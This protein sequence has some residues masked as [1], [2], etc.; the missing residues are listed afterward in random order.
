MKNFPCLIRLLFQKTLI[1]K[2]QHCVRSCNVLFSSFLL[3][4]CIFTL[5]STASIAQISIPENAQL[6]VYGNGWVC[7]RGFRQAGDKCVRVTMPENAQLNVYGNGW[8]CQMGF[9][10]VS[11]SCIEMSPEEAE[12]QRIQM[13]MLAARAKAMNKEFYVDGEK[14][15]LAEISRK[16]DVYRYSDNYG[17]IECSG[18][19]LRAVERKCE[20]YFSGRYEKTGELECRGSDLNPIE[21]NC[22]ATMYSD[23]YADI[24]C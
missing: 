3:S 8:V 9:K 11:Q 15:T 18:S 1:K 14:F 16:C 23:S 17:D 13:K 4:A 6:N 5:L 7:K 24:D 22:S 2:S 20:A 19:K 10:R 21:R 12:Q